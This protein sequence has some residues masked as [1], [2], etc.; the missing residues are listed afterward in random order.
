MAFIHN[1]FNLQFCVQLNGGGGGIRTP[2]GC[3]TPGGFQDRSLQPGLGTP[4][5]SSATEYNLTYLKRE[6]N[7]FF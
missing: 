1:G 2:A 5:H 7:N 6:V 3:N 4:P